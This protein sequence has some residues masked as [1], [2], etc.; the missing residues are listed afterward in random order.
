MILTHLT[1][2]NVLKYNSLD[3]S[4]L[5]SRGVIGISGQNESGKSTIGETICFA[6]FG[7][8]WALDENNR[9]KIIRWGENRC[10]VML[11]LVAP[12]GKAYEVTRQLDTDGNHSAK[13]CYAGEEEP[14]VKGAEAVKLSLE[15][16]LGVN[17]EEFIESFYLA[18]RELTAPHPHSD[19]IKS[20]AGILTLEKAHDS[21]KREI[22]QFKTGMVNADQKHIQIQ[23][24]LDELSLDAGKLPGMTKLYQELKEAS[25]DCLLESSEIEQKA[26]VYSNSLREYR[27]ASA[28][29]ERTRFFELLF[30]F[31]GV[32]SAI[33]WF[34]LSIM[35]HHQL[36]EFIQLLLGLVPQWKT[37]FVPYLAWAAGGFGLLGIAAWMT[38]LS[39]GPK[40]RQF[41]GKTSEF[42][43]VIEESMER[44]GDGDDLQLAGA[45]P[46]ALDELVNDGNSAA[47]LANIKLH[48]ASMQE[49]GAIT[50]QETNWLR[51]LSNIE[52]AR[53]QELDKEIEDERNRV[54][55]AERL[56]NEQQSYQ[57]SVETNSRQVKMRALATQLL[58][59]S[60]EVVAKRFNLEL[61]DGAG[62]ILPALTQ[63]RYKH[64]KLNNELDVQLFSS[65]KG[66]FLDFD[67]VSSGT[68]RQ[69][70]LAVRLSM[71]QNLARDII[72]GD[73]FMFL[74]EPFAFF[75]QER[76]QHSLA[77]MKE[78]KHLP[79]IWIVAQEFPGEADF[80]RQI[81]CRRLDVD[82]QA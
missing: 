19:A 27:S 40:I 17:Y 18:Q 46:G 21:L 10:R 49:I 82:L 56:H 38:G 30:L 62:T 6:L 66:D 5:P 32:V 74:D 31:I 36:A 77:A 67:E 20:M 63:E 22:D 52:K 55:T 80:A 78:M 4:E 65:E 69:I 75:D 72:K 26:D 11:G 2:N 28:S 61:R 9:H 81:N 29:R 53:M 54:N 45:E 42:C 14:I 76:T 60:M 58:K 79:Q 68:Q 48:Q 50:A 37:D 51:S 41:S 1:A 12:D 35:P 64:I 23:E 70:L 15:Q 25:E 7:R 39:N 71:S 44:R 59:G 73:Q 47:I 16:L 3:L 8:T 57:S 43:S 13:L 34:M 33:S 24:E